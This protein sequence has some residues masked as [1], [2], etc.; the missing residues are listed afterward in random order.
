MTAAPTPPVPSADHP[1][2]PAFVLSLVRKLA[3]H[4]F[5]SPI[6]RGAAAT[7]GQ[8]VDRHGAALFDLFHTQPGGMFLPVVLGSLR[9]ILYRL[10]WPSTGW[11]RGR[12]VRTSR[13]AGF[14]H[15]ARYARG[16]ALGSVEAASLL[17]TPSHG[18]VGRWVMLSRA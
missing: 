6:M 18:P 17:D 3:G 9:S 12:V 13:A 11:V 2:A 5:F 14:S 1:F 8:P 15:V 10:S 7:F 4:V 16:S